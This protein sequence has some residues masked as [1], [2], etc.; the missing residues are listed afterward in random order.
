MA[1]IILC[2]TV[3]PWRNGTDRDAGKSRDVETA[4]EDPLLLLLYFPT[5]P[6]MLLLGFLILPSQDDESARLHLASPVSCAVLDSSAGARI[7]AWPD[8]RDDGC[9]T[10]N[11]F[12]RLLLRSEDVATSQALRCMSP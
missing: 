10:M 1:E 11:A 6:G 7:L 12:S 5:V 2:N 8:R 3:G 9:R 4:G